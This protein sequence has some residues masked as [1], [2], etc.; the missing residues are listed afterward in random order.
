MA[1][2]RADARPRY[3]I[4]AALLFNP[5][6]GS[7]YCWSLF[8]APLETRLALPRADVSLIFSIAV[9]AFTAGTL[10][11]PRLYRLLPPAGLLLAVATGIAAGLALAGLSSTWW[12]L[13][14]GY[15]GLFGG[16]AGLAY[17]ITLQVMALA[18]PERRGLA[19]GLG[20]S[21]FAVGS[22]LFA[23]LLGSVLPWL[24]LSGAWFGLATLFLAVGLCAALLLAG[25]G[26]RL[27]PPA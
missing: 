3:A 8:V 27:P 24:G 1:A 15:G 7:L 16:G 20:V 6:L 25:S 14:L 21:G 17:S 11:S 4:A 13:A 23:L 22:I 9:L 26:L 12:T 10:L 2:D 18:L 5:M 19:A